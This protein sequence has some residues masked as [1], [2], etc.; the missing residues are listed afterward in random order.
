MAPRSTTTGVS[1][2]L[3]LAACSRHHLQDLL[4]LL[5]PFNIYLAK[6]VETSASKLITAGP[7]ITMTQPQSGIMAWATSV[8]LT[9][10]N[11]PGRQYLEDQF[12]DQ[13]TFLTDYMDMVMRGP[14][15]ECVVPLES[16]SM[17]HVN[18]NLGASLTF[19]RRPAVR[20]M[21]PMQRKRARQLRPR[22]NSNPS[23]P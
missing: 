18:T 6:E 14:Q 17:W 9:M 13:F 23:S 11:D 20:R 10:A 5:S 19:S 16:Y 21:L 2:V 3:V 4:S 7:P 22:A 12:N 8:R 1:L 15:D